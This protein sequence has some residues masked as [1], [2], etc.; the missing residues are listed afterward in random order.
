MNPRHF[1]WL[2]AP[3]AVLPATGQ[4]RVE[5][6]FT[7]PSAIPDRGQ[8]AD[9][10]VLG[11]LGLSSISGVA[12]DLALS[13]APAMRLGDLYGTLTYGTASENERVSVLLN[14]PGVSNSN[15]WGSSLGSASITL[16][17]TLGT[18]SV[19]GISAGSGIYQADG[20][21][22]VNPLAAPVVYNPADATTG[23]A[24][25]NGGILASNTWV[26]MLADTRQG[27]AAQ[28]SGW[29][30]R[31]TGMPAAGG[32]I[33]PGLGGG[34]SDTP[35]ATDTD[36]KATL[37]TTGTGTGGVTASVTDQ[38]TLSGGLSGNGELT[39]TGGGNLVIGGTSAGFGGHLQVDAGRVSL[40]SGATLGSGSGSMEIAPGAT[41]GGLGGI[42]VSTEIHGV[43]APGNSPGLQTFAAGL[44]YGGDAV[45]EWEIV[46]NTLGLRGTDYDAVDLT[47][48]DLGINPLATLAILAS[49]TDY[50]QAAWAAP[51]SFAVIDVS[52]GGSVSG[53]FTLDVSGAG[54]FGTYGSWSTTVS[55][56]DVM[57]VWTPIPESGTFLLGG[58]GILLM[59]RRN[60]SSSSWAT[61]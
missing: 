39:K 24:A 4:I 52:G 44:T 16:D 43:H 33:N 61:P 25:L 21:L 58:L 54:S 8:V 46:G 12:V 10:R 14:R 42:N 7:T 22:S 48:G 47:G 51:R 17:D 30:L 57:A 34:I 37:V 49:G 13:G 3:A 20:R 19:F 31:V 50:S 2:L 36:V 5:T 6:K 18:A 53:S 26:L 9:V 40:A 45:L 28:L 15:P 35:G 41:L 32:S 60:R 27:A 38:M 1:L 23:L 29:T 55:G 59:F 11:D 56:G